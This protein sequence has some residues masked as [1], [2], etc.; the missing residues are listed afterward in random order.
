MPHRPNDCFLAIRADTCERA[1]ACVWPEHL[2]NRNREWNENEGIEMCA[3]AENERAKKKGARQAG[4]GGD[5]KE[6]KEYW[7]CQSC[8]IRSSTICIISTAIRL[9]RGKM[10]QRIISERERRRQTEH[11]AICRWDS[12]SQMP[13]FSIRSIA[14]L[15]VFFRLHKEGRQI[16]IC[17]Y[18]R[19]IENHWTEKANERA[20]RRNK[21]N[22]SIKWFRRNR[23]DKQRRE[24]AV[25]R[26]DFFFLWM[27]RLRWGKKGPDA[28]QADADEGST[29][30][31]LNLWIEKKI[32]K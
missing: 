14:R 11:S 32:N 10:I 28:A 23:N 15:S 12:V 16:N 5:E 13:R 21:T 2:I 7:R 24:L 25:A 17:T 8:A 26:K 1:R 20:K 6:R 30:F 9:L 3:K 31:C 29:H 22:E 27:E 19:H 18:R 4:D